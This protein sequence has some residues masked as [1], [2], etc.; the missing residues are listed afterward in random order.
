MKTHRNARFVFGPLGLLFLIGCT[1]GG[2]LGGGN[3]ENGN[4]NG[5]ASPLPPIDVTIDFEDLADGETVTNQ[6]GPEV[7][8]SAEPGYHVE[9]IEYASQ[10]GAGPR[11]ICIRPDGGGNCGAREFYLEF[12]ASLSLLEFLIPAPGVQSSAGNLAFVDS[13]G[14]VLETLAL[15]E[16]TNLFDDIPEGCVAVHFVDQTDAAGIGVDDIVIRL[17]P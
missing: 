17:Q 14:E 16:G 13:A 2:P 5:D 1:S 8:F 6:Y 10:A 9:V 11:F 12:S 15:Q 4:G 3:G 7:V